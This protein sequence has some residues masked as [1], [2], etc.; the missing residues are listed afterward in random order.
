MNELY[1]ATANKNK[2]IEFSELL[3]SRGIKVISLLD[4]DPGLNIIENG[5]T[6]EENALIKVRALF[7]KYG[8]PCISDD[9]GICIDALDGGPGIYSARYLGSDCSYLI[10]NQSII[11][12]CLKSDEWKAHYVCV[13]AYIDQRSKEYTFRGQLDGKIAKTMCGNNGFGYDPIF[14][15][16]PYKKTL[17]QVSAKE[18]DAISHR[19][20]ALFKF[21]K[22][23]DQED[24]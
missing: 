11:D 9:S 4:I 10:K 17:A 23:L 12:A 19:Q 1:I 7:A 8:K 2:V 16:P 3:K 21:L 24:K 22:H 20:K 14:Y 6:F 5:N 15:Y 18:K 13:I